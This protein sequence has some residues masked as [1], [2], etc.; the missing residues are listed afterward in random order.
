MTALS[1][2]GTG[3]SGGI[4]TNR[5]GS[6]MNRPDKKARHHHAGLGE[7]VALAARRRNTRP[8]ARPDMLP[9]AIPS[10]TQSGGF[11]EPARLPMTSGAVTGVPGS[12]PPRRAVEAIHRPALEGRS[13]SHVG[14]GQ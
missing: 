1:T 14:I 7:D 6:S 8:L 2:P 3:T 4:S 11:R 5:P 13:D 12:A 9:P 10:H